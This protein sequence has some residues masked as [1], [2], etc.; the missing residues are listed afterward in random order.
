MRSPFKLHSEWADPKLTE[1]LAPNCVAEAG[2]DFG[3][4]DDRIRLA[5]A[6]GALR[7]GKKVGDWTIA[8]D[9]GAGAAGLDSEKLLEKARSPIV[10]K[11]V[12]A[13]TAAFHQLQ[14][15]QRPTF[16][17][18]TEIGDRALFSGFARVAPLAAAIDSMID[19]AEG[20]ESFAAH[21]GKPPT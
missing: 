9:I 8:A 6:E 1:Y 21:F 3:V 17:V 5:L 7:Q 4:H 11:R 16:V 20:Y 12:R 19:D 2:R 15:T 10:E 18:D 13:D 14:V